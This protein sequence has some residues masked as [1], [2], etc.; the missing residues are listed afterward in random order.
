MKEIPGSGI[1]GS[2]GGEHYKIISALPDDVDKED[3]DIVSS[4]ISIY[5]NGNIVAYACLGDKLHS[6]AKKTIA[7][8]KNLGI[9]TFILSGDKSIPVSSVAKKLCIANDQISPN[10]F[11]EKKNEIIKSFPNSLMVGD[12]A[13]DSLAMSSDTVS[14]AVQGSVESCLVAADIYVTKEGVFPVEDLILLSK[15]TFAIIKRNLIFS[16]IYNFA[17]GLAAL[18]G[19]IS[20]LTAAILMPVSS[21]AV[22]C[23]SVVGTKFIR[24]FN[25]INFSLNN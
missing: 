13:N 2:V 22:L 9:K 7:S 12:G 17:G 16:F 23:S 10:L 14:I 20:P 5:K 15:N 18:L 21:L 8:L 11:P 25:K 4:L 19:Y 1:S 3:S 6:D 24:R